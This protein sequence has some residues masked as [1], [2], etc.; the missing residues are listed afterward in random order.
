MFLAA[1][2]ST[3]D[4]HLNWGSSYIV[5]DVYKRFFK[6]DAGQ[7]HYVVVS[8][9]T[10]VVLMLVAG[11]VALQITSITAAWELLWAMGAG[12]GAVL[13]LRWF[14]WRI[15]AWS[16]ISALS[17]SLVIA[18][19]LQVHDYLTEGETQFYVKLLTVAFGS[20]AV[21]LTVTFL[22]RPEPE[23]VL[24]KFTERVRP[25]GWW[26]FEVQKGIVSYKTLIAW[27]GGVMVV[28][29]GMFLIGGLVLRG[30]SEALIST[31]STSCGQPR[32]ST[33]PPT[34]GSSEARMPA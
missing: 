22:T 25:G 15:N 27:I 31:M 29:G 11:F 23:E 7:K 2:M 24:K 30:W 6:P 1:Y 4:T 16:E 9:I 32:D 26:P 19:V 13:I 17:A 20:A 8:K 14:W 28:F 5:N 12:I 3:I 10:S 21:W 34:S 33:T 18:T